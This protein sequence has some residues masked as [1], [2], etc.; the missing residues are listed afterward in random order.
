MDKKRLIYS[1]LVPPKAILVKPQPEPAEDTIS[2]QSGIIWGGY[3]TIFSMTLFTILLSVVFPNEPNGGQMYYISEGLKNHCGWSVLVLGIGTTVIFAIQAINAVHLKSKYIFIFLGIE[4][5]GWFIILGIEST[6]WIF[7]Y[8]G[9]CLFVLGNICFHWN[10]SRDATY[11][12]SYYQSVNYLT[13]LFS[14]I[15][16]IANRV[17]DMMKGNNT[18][19]STAVSLEFFLVIL[20][21]VQQCFLNHGFGKFEKIHLYFELKQEII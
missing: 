7:H 17:S 19:K 3:I 20:M 1:M 10:S 16:L 12:S 13:I 18:A 21:G 8:V 2:I 9:L 5:L 14:L 15:F 6:G 4:V 11:G